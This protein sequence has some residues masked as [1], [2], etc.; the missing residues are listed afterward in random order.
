MKATLLVQNR[1]RA[2]TLIELL[3]VIAIIAIL[4]ALL[5]PA[6]S[7]AKAQA[8]Q[9]SCINNLKQIGIGFGIYVGDSQY[10]PG[11][12]VGGGYVWMSRI[13]FS[14]GNNRKIFNC[15]SADPVTAWDTNINHTLGGV[16][17]LGVYDPWYVSDS[18]RFSYGIVDWGLDI[19]WPVP[20]GLGGDVGSAN[21]T[22]DPLNIHN[23]VKATTV[24][25][26]ARM[27]CVADTKGD[28]NGMWEANLDPTDTTYD[29]G[30]WEGQLP[31]D[32]HDYK[33][34]VLSC[35]GHVEIA[36]RNQMVDPSINALW[37]SR[38]NND[39]DPHNTIT[40][41]VLPPGNGPGQANALD[42]SF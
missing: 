24:V 11:S 4:A 7:S 17:D 19:G 2:F 9:T 14:A 12:Q 1:N 34:D 29:P 6:L 5:L 13:F 37:R 23:M 35:D 42:P 36:I 8:K 28:P 39:N 32:R 38:W 22:S 41:P 15:P 21:N 18:S 16:G 10:Y 27:I 3:V 25:A 26:P 40:W 31:S 33:C 30:D 20:L